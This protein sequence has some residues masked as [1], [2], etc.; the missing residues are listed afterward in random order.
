MDAALPFGHAGSRVKNG[1]TRISAVPTVDLTDEERA[2]VT[3]LIRRAIEED[4]PLRS[5]KDARPGIRTPKGRARP[6]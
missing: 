6:S 3:A 2:T 1:Q 4:D 5:A